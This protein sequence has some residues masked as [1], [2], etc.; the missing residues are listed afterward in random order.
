M[1]TSFKQFLVGCALFLTSASLTMQ[2][3][4]G[5]TGA[6]TINVTDPS[7]ALISGATI[8]V[9]S[10]ATGQVRTQ[11]TESSGSYTFTLLPPGQYEVSISATGFRP[12]T[13]PNVTVNVTETHQL[14]QQLTLG[15][16][17]QEVTVASSV[18]NVQTENATLG[19]VVNNKEISDLPLQTRNFTQIMGLSAGVNVSV[20]NAAA[21]GR[22][23]VS[24]YSNGQEDISN[25]FQID[26]VTVNEFGGGNATG[27]VFFGEIPT[28]S[29]DAL[30]EFKVQTAQYDASYGRNSGAQVN[31]VTKSGTNALHGSLFEFFRNEDLN[32][33]D[34]FR[35][36]SGEPRGL[37]RQNQ[38]GG[39]VGG[40]IVKDKLFF[41]LSYQGTKQLNGV[42]STGAST[43]DVPAQLTNDRSA[44]ALGAEF[45]PANNPKVNTNTFAGGAQV[46]CN[47]S[48]INPVAL[49]ILNFPVKQ[50]GFAIPT[51]QTILNAGT[52]SAVGFSAFSIPSTFN[53]NQGLANLD[54]VISPKESLALRS[55]YAIAPQTTYLNP[56]QPP[57]SGAA[58]LSGS[59]L[60]SA[61][62]TSLL[63][64]RMVNEARFSLFYV[65]ASN[66]TIDQVTPSGIGMLPLNP[67]FNV[68]PIITV[69]GLFSIGGGGT[70]G[71]HAPQQTYEYADQLSWTNGRH[72]FRFGADVQRVDY[73]IDV[74]G[75]GRGGLTFNTFSDFLL[76][77]S[78]AQNGSPTGLSNL[79][80]STATAL[81]PGG[82]LNR[83][84]AN[85]L[86]VFAQDD[87]KV[88][89]RLTLN[90]GLRWEYDGTGYDVD[91]ANG[92][93]NASW[94][95]DQT[96]PI[97][98][99]AGTFVGYTVASNFN[100]VL[101]AGVVRRKLESSYQRPRTIGRLRA[102]NRFCL[103]ATQFNWKVRYTRR[104]RYFL[105][106]D[107]GQYL[108]AGIE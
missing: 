15:A 10:A 20:T 19:G 98:P 3:Q 89:Q 75:I 1:K 100:G 16:Q 70:D 57:G 50:G 34:F 77:E 104:L 22:G 13:V 32:A 48:N 92:G 94:V 63:S 30:Q 81:P 18:E 65:R 69:P 38:Y 72:T 78:A 42:S 71:S 91:P 12:I 106:S 54:Y 53:E 59:Q 105:S 80:T 102:A 2:A 86:S 101:P 108:A 40:R 66:N 33:N 68:M 29:P 45:C 56:G 88:S 62:L 52:A 55:Q 4:T 107:A 6:L 93:G 23:F 31:I 46:A 84:R 7:G 21:L 99:A 37:L 64:S 5:G 9:T 90:L 36:R 85:Q 95:L 58:S 79:Q 51:P 82:S 26:G 83:M 17:Q 49:A 41:F 67:Q 44:A 27:T 96:V 61:K 74:T 47:G 73:N 87:F 76:G 14:N 60:E 103:A 24:I 35:N 43:V 97:P 11:V 8:K 25:T 39:T 28:P